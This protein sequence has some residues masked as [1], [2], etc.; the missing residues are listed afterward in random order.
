MQH[1]ANI[2]TAQVFRDQEFTSDM[3]SRAVK[4]IEDVAMLRSSQMPEV[5]LASPLVA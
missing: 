3:R 1:D 2:C 4:R 5:R